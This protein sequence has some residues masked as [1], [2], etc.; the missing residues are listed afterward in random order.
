M[1]SIYMHLNLAISSRPAG[2]TN[3]KKA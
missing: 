2:L 3:T 1:L